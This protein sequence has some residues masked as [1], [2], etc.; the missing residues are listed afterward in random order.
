MDHSIDR[1]EAIA[2]A[3]LNDTFSPLIEQAQ[4]QLA[5]VG[6]SFSGRSLSQHT[7]GIGIKT[8]MIM[9]AYRVGLVIV[10][11]VSIRPTDVIDRAM[12]CSV[13]SYDRATGALVV[14]PQAG[15]ITGTGTYADWSIRVSVT[16]NLDTYSREEVDGEIAD[17]EDRLTTQVDTSIAAIIDSAPAGLNT[18][19]KL[20]EAIGGVSGQTEG[21]LS[22]VLKRSNNLSDV[23]SAATARSN[24]GLGNVDNTRDINKPVSSAQQAAINAV[25]AGTLPVGTS[26]FFFQATVPIGWIRLTTH[27][28]KGIRIVSG[29][30]GGVGGVHA[31]STVFGR[32]TV[33]NTTLDGN[34]LPSHTHGLYDPTHTH[35]VADYQ[36][37]HAVGDPGHNHHVND[38]GH[39]HGVSD[40][41][42]QHG[43]DHP[44][45]PSFG[46]YQGGGDAWGVSDVGAA[47]GAGTDWRGTGIGINGSGT[48]IWL[49]GSGTGIGLDYRFANIANYGAGTG[50]SVNAAGA[51]WGHTHG[52]DMRCQYVDVLIGVKS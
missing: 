45:G 14:E 46:Y 1:L 12:I 40:P 17:I 24:I 5:D 4:Q 21:Q 32:T 20:A 51:S 2:L 25:V 38:P 13:L 15:Y 50:Q 8:F 26:M 42:H 36:H 43:Y 9:E 7:I 18:L 30:G 29:V 31:W 28:D 49:N 44:G 22:T 27:N 11:Y 6:V 47:Y 48:G 10:D 35:G 23:L 39:G 19:R 33:D 41:G 16:P 3:R 37:I 52:I 34:T